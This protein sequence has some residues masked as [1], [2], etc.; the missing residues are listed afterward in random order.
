MQTAG[1]QLALGPGPEISRDRGPEAGRGQTQVGEGTP[2]RSRPG[3]TRD[4]PSLT[5][6]LPVRPGQAGAPNQQEQRTLADLTP[7]PSHTCHATD[8]ARRPAHA[9]AKD[10]QGRKACARSKCAGSTLAQRM[11]SSDRDPAGVLNRGPTKGSTGGERAAAVGGRA[12]VHGAGG[13]QPRTKK[14]TAR[15]ALCMCVRPNQTNVTHRTNQT[16]GLYR[17]AMQRRKR[18]GRK[19]G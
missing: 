18:R 1:R 15:R 11:A 10:T 7:R 6:R 5:R 16:G 3:L 8:H 2:A 14:G 13:P 17:S 19:C 4:S 9:V 12:P